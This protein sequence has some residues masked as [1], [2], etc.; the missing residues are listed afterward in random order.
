M[1]KIGNWKQIENNKYGIRFHNKQPNATYRIFGFWAEI[2]GKERWDV[3]TS[4]IY[5]RTKVSWTKRKTFKKKSKALKFIK[6]WME[7]HPKGVKKR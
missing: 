1:A 5:S 2:K 6:S 7:K 4:N 3:V